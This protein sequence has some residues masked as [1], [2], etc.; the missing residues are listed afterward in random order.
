MRLSVSAARSGALVINIVLTVAASVK[1]NIDF[2]L[3][4]SVVVLFVLI[5]EAP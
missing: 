3:F 1:G 5:L 2:I 4:L